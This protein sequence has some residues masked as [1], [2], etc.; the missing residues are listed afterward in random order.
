[1]SRHVSAENLARLDLDALKPRK[2]ARIRAHLMTCT[3]CTRLG[4]Q[5][6]AVSSTLASVSVSY[7]AMPESLCTRL[8]A[9]IASESAQ[10]LA[11][12]PAAEAGRRDLPERSYRVRP[13]RRGWQL[14]G[15]S[16]P[17]T[18]L[19]AAAGALVIVGVG[20]YAIAT[21]VSGPNSG[22]AASSSGAAA[23]PGSATSQL[24]LGPRVQYGLPQAPKT[25]RMVSSNM[26]FHR[27]KLAAEA[28]AAVGAARARG[29]VGFNS[30][31]GT[32][33]TTSG[34]K[35]SEKATAPLPASAMPGCLD[36]IAGGSTVL[37]VDMARYDGKPAIIIVTAASSAHKAQV[38][39]VAPDCSASHPDVLDHLGL[40]RT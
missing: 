23:L 38:W 25:I 27:S 17:A 24:K 28:V 11:D 14:P 3:V 8:D 34:A 5:V 13:Q 35:T 9:A 10:R 26:N 15:L 18:R 31:R 37:L 19:V 40:S 39:V 7:P 22:T 20:G 21:N 29:A 6:S 1:V 32:P 33:A 2:A 4:G 16:V 30:V 12:A 36:R